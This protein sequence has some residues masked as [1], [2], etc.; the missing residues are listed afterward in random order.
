MLLHSLG[1][2]RNFPLAVAHAGADDLGLG[3]D[4][5][6][7]VL[8]VAQLQLLLGHLNKQ[9]RT[10]QLIHIDRDFIEQVVKTGKCPLANPAITTLPHCP[11]TWITSVS[12]FLHSI[13]GKVITTS[14][15]IIPLQREND[16]YI[17]QLAIDGNFCVRS[18]QQC[19]MWLQAATLADI[20]HA[21]GRRL[22]AWA[23]VQSTKGR[24]ST[25]KW[26]NQGKPPRT[27]WKK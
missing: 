3:I 7:C 23:Y 25:L 22:E 21:D 15:R 1:L 26:T 11:N 5:I 2:G 19:R 18:I 8:G 17:M 10:G 24:E 6:V 27:T 9:D 16:K 12:R 13:D 4:D 20:S 14:R